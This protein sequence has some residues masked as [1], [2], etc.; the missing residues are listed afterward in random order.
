MAGDCR[1][2]NGVWGASMGAGLSW[3]L[4]DDLWQ[5]FLL[6]YPGAKR[7]G[8]T[9]KSDEHRLGEVTIRYTENYNKKSPLLLSLI[10]CEMQ[11]V[12]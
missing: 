5:Y 11:M 7:C 9:G 1:R 4:S 8:R 2:M 3:S 10:H 12:M 6:E